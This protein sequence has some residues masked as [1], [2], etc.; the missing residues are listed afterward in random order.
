[1]CRPIYNSSI[2]EKGSNRDKAKGLLPSLQLSSFEF[3]ASVSLSLEA[4]K[5]PRPLGSSSGYQILS[6]DL[7]P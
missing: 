2:G 5:L 4:R 6:I 7:P 1:M 3:W